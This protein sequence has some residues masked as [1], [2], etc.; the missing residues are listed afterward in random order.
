MSVADDLPEE[1]LE[2]RG[3]LYAVSF[4]GRRTLYPGLHGHLRLSDHEVIVDR[5]IAIREVEPPPVEPTEAQL[6]QEWRRCEAAAMCIS[7]A[8]MQEL[9][10]N[11]N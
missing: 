4:V 6:Q 1:R 8:N 9:A 2:G 3:G 5:F 10:G 11:P 7:T